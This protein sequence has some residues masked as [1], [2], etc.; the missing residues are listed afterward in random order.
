MRQIAVA[1]GAVSLLVVA[2]ASRPQ[3]ALAER[4][5]SQSTSLRV[6]NSLRTGQG[7]GPAVPVLR[8]LRQPSTPQLRDEIADSLV[9]FILEKH[10]DTSAVTAVSDARHA[11]GSAGG[12]LLPG[13]SY[14]GAGVRLKRIAESVDLAYSGGVLYQLGQLADKGESIRLLTQLAQSTGPVATPA[15]GTMLQYLGEDGETAVRGL[16]ERDEVRNPAARRVISSVAA[17]RGWTAPVRPPPG[18]KPGWQ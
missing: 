14:A 6:M 12:A 5:Q 3:E 9:A 2:K 4:T 8:Q 1:L 16:F 13:V 17:E 18:E 7:S 15:I 10:A 11:L